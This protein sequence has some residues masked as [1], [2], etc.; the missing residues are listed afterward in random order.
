MEHRDGHRGEDVYKRQLVRYSIR[1]DE[2][3]EPIL[4]PREGEEE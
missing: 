1:E 4:T 2:A 3:R